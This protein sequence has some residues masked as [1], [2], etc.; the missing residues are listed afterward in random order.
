MQQYIHKNVDKKSAE[1]TYYDGQLK[2]LNFV[3]DKVLTELKTKQLN[4]HDEN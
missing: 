4:F 2:I 3:V 1:E